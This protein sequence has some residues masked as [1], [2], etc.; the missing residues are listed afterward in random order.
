M[1][2]YG[3]YTIDVFDLGFSIGFHL[4][5]FNFEKVSTYLYSP[6]VLN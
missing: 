5:K 3:I 1:H 4:G 6:L 2:I